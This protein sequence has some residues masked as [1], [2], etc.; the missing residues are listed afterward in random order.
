MKNILPARVEEF[1]MLLISLLS[2]T[3]FLLI[4]FHS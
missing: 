3:G 2:A 4:W 1:V